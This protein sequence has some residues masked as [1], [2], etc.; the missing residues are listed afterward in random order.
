M[1][2]A[3]PKHQSCSCRITFSNCSFGKVKKSDQLMF[4]AP[5]SSFKRNRK[6]SKYDPIGVYVCTLPPSAV[7]PAPP[8]DRKRHRYNCARGFPSLLPCN[9]EVFSY[10]TFLLHFF[11]CRYVTNLEL[12]QDGSS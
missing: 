6:T 9:F 1:R 10:I 3:F 5:V 8:P 4:V 7:V 12:D 2:V 11:L